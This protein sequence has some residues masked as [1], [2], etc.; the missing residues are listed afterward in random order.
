MADYTHAGRG[1]IAIARS[2]LPGTEL[3]YINLVGE[4]N[5]DGGDQYT[6]WDRFSRLIDQRWIRT[7]TRTALERTKYGY[8]QAGNRLW[9][10]NSVADAASAN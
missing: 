9:Q 1:K 5:G 2:P 7:G 10:D 8:N 4:P 6:G 3:T